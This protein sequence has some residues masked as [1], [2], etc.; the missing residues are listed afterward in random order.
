MEKDLFSL[1]VVV[2][3]VLVGSE[4]IEPINDEDQLV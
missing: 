2:L 4:M 3:E 1:G